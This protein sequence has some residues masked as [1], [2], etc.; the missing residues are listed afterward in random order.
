MAYTA[1]DG[2][3]YGVTRTSVDYARAAGNYNPN[4]GRHLTGETFNGK[5]VIRIN[6]VDYVE[7]SWKNRAGQHLLTPVSQ[8][9]D[10]NGNTVHYS[11]TAPV[12]GTTNNFSSTPNPSLPPGPKGLCRMGDKNTGGGKIKMPGQSSVYINGKLASVWMD[13]ITKHN[14]HKHKNVIEGDATI[15]I[16]GKIATFNGCKNNCDHIMIEASSDVFCSGEGTVLK[17]VKKK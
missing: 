7:N 15:Y 5:P 12:S 6:N 2:T 1:P 9:T 10:L 14:K 8:L 17:K 3:V 16:E 13:R 11:S 4:P